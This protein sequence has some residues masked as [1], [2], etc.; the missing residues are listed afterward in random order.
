M[1]DKSD[2]SI[3][4]TESHVG[5]T[6][7]YPR[8]FRLGLHVDL[9][10]QELIRDSHHDDPSQGC[11][12]L[13]RVMGLDIAKLKTAENKNWTAVRSSISKDVQRNFHGV[14]W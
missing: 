13:D 2:H 3:N 8:P 1:C 4:L 11:S 14:G 12:E 9:T 7:I 10:V 6:S 5:V